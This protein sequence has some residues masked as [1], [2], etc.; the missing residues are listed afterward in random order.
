MKLKKTIVLIITLFSVQLFYGQIEKD[1]LNPKYNNRPYYL[2]DNELNAFE[3]VKTQYEY[4][5]KG[6]GY[7]GVSTYLVA[8]NSK[9]NVRFK[10]NELPFIILKSEKKIDAD[11]LLT[12][13]LAEQ[14]KKKKDKNKRRFKISAMKFGGG[15]VD[16]SE[17]IMKFEIESIGENVYSIKLNENLEVGE[18]AILIS[19]TVNNKD[20]I[21]M[22]N[23]STNI[24]CFG[25]D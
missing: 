4:K 8:F 5:S 3:K 11:E 22:A 18:Y 15:L 13:Y 14:P 2:N 16:T 19:S 17:N 6:L 21:S 12:V 9:S 7:G 20:L 1:V 23:Y 24:F 10:K 25:I